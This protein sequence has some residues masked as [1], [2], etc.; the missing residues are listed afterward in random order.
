MAHNVKILKQIISEQDALHFSAENLE[1]EVV[2]LSFAE[3]RDFVNFTK[4]FEQSRLVLSTKLQKKISEKRVNK[5][6]VLAMFPGG[7]KHLDIVCLDFTGWIKVLCGAQGKIRIADVGTVRLDVRI[8]HG[9]FFFVGDKT[10]INEARVVAVN[11]EIV[12]GTDN[13]FSDEILLQGY[14]QHGI[15]DLNTMEIINTDRI[16]ITI[17]SHCW[18]ARRATIMP[19]VTLGHGS[20]VGACSVVTSDVQ[21]QTLV[22]GSPAR[23]LRDNV[24]WSRLFNR[25]DDDTKLYV[26]NFVGKN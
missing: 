16:G 4:E 1:T 5:I 19:G 6:E 10:T 7:E 14:D 20:I 8:G 9:G 26:E 15:I 2:E 17:E 23:M 25:L 13:I 12:I 24:T 21:P 3:A 22:A 18:V 11:S